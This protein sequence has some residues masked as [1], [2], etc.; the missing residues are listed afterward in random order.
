MTFRE[1]RTAWWNGQVYDKSPIT[2]FRNSQSIEK[3]IAPFFDN[4]EIGCIDDIFINNYIQSELQHGNRINGKGLCQN[5]VRKNI[6]IINNIFD[7]AVNKHIID[8]EYNPML[9]VPKLKLQKTKEFS[10]FTYED[11]EKLIEVARPKWLGD[12][13][14]LAYLTGVRKCEIYGLQWSDI[15]FDTGFLTVN[16]S[17]TSYAPDNKFVGEPKTRTSHRQIKLDDRT[18]N[19]LKKR[20]TNR[21]YDDWVFPNQYGE[22]MS[23]WYNVKYFRRACV[24]AG[25]PI[26]R[27][28]DLRHTHITDLVAAGISLPVVQQRAGHSDIK[29]TMRYTHINPNMQQS[30]VNFLNKRNQEFHDKL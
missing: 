5:T 2:I 22:L 27:F 8:K 25:I 11:V 6:Q 4:M 28:H 23:P 16:R 15:D 14:L 12:M 19:M 29:M 13:I 1:I 30:S 10:V 21:K 20:R 9:L 24:A 18:I 26:R 17:V 3:H 7:Y